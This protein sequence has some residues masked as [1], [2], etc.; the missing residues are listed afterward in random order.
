MKKNLTIKSDLNPMKS[1]ALNGGISGW[2]TKEQ[3]L[4]IYSAS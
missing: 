4:L 2:I 3:L 1:T